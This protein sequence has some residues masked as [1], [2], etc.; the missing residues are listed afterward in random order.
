MKVKA[1]GPAWGGG[2]RALGKTSRDWLVEWPALDEED[3]ERET[4]DEEE[5]ANDLQIGDHR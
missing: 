3:L 5:R 2:K 4:E 1:G